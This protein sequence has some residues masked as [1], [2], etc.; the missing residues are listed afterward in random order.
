MPIYCPSVMPL[1]SLEELH[2]LQAISASAGSQ[3]QE[4]LGCTVTSI[5]IKVALQRLL[6]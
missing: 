6:A 2:A 3:R 5:S 1:F 4:L